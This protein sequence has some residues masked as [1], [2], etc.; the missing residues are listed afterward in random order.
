MK[1]FHMEVAL[2]TVILLSALAD[3]CSSLTREKRSLLDMVAT[4]WCYRNRLGI[5]LLGINLYGCYCGTGGSGATVDSVDQCCF[6]HDCCYHHSRVFLKCRSKV[7]WK[8]YS[9]RCKGAETYCMSRGMCSRMACECDKQ[10]AECLMKATPN[11]AHFFYDKQQL[12]PGPK[13]TCPDKF[14]NRSEILSWPQT[15][16]ISQNRSQPQQQPPEK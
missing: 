14:P 1:V 16:P 7:K 8:N 12:C 3:P 6:L 4:L 9:F 10:F 13:S 5:S 2:A 15:T 11:M